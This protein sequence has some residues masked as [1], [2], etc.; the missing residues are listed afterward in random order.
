MVVNGREIEQVIFS[1]D[2]K[3]MKVLTAPNSAASWRF[4]VS[5][6]TMAF[7]RHRVLAR[8]IF[9]AQSGTRTRTL[10]VVFSRCAHRAVSPV[11]TG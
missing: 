5:P 1:Q 11:F 7:G 10:R 9:R 3:L 8:I 6:R 4:P 2:G